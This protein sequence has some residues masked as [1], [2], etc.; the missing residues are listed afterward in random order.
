MIVG[1][2]LITFRKAARQDLSSLAEIIGTASAGAVAFGDTNEA[3][4]IL[5]NL[6]GQKSIVAGRLFASTGADLATYVRA[7]ANAALLPEL[8]QPDRTFVE[9][10][11]IKAF[12]TIRFRE[13]SIGTVYLEEDMAR[14]Y[15]RL[16]RYA[17]IVLTLIALLV[18][19][20]YLLSDRL[21]RII[22]AP[23]EDLSMLAHEIA[24][25][26][27]YSARA[28]SKETTRWVG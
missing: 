22:A 2:E 4:Q 16:Y 12:R 3:N 25:E 21:R 11:H 5:E 23:I 1:Y 7:D 15:S 20:V 17:G 28:K 26:K 18:P 27:K 24:A 8:P 19:L 14:A 9:G 13:D 6:K 10:N